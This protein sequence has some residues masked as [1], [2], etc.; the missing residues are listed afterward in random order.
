MTP[1]ALTEYLHRNI[2]LSAALQAQVLAFDNESLEI[3][4][5][6]APNLNHRGTGFGGSLATLAILGG[7]AL[8]N[9]ALQN[10]GLKAR[11][12]VQ[13]SDC[14]FFEPATAD[15]TAVTTLSAPTWARFLVTLAK[16][17]R[18][19]ITVDTQIRADGRFVVSHHGTFVAIADLYS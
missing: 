19:R 11:I 12:V 14:E 8:L 5:P 15:F 2:P 9:Q 17:G 16:R 10:Q 4:A 18:A 7:W 6:L 13:R 1:E 3:T